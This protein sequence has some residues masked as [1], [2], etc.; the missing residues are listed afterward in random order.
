MVLTATSLIRHLCQITMPMVA[1]LR[2]LCASRCVSPKSVSTANI[3]YYIGTYWYRRSRTVKKKALITIGVIAVA[4]II[5]S[6]FGYLP[7]TFK[8]ESAIPQAVDL[9]IGDSVQQSA[10]VGNVAAIAPPSTKPAALSAPPIRLMTIPWNATMG[11]HYATGGVQTTEGSL[12]AKYGVKLRLEK[13]DDVEKMKQSQVLF[14]NALAKGQAH[15]T[16]GHHFVIIMGDG[17][18]Q[19]I[20]AL[21]DLLKDLGD[22]YRA[23]IV[24]AIGYSRG[25]DGC[26]GPQ[27]WKDNPESMKGGVIA[28][29]LRDGDWNLCLYKA[30]NDGIKNNPDETTY[31]PDAINWVS[32]SDFMKAV[33]LYVGNHCEDRKVVKLGKLTGESKHI[34]VQGVAT[35]TPGDVALAKNKGGLV[36]LISTK[37]NAYQ[38]PAVI[39]GIRAWDIRNSKLVEGLLQ[40]ALEGSEQVKHFDTA[41]SKAATIAA[42][43]YGDQTPAYWAKYY[44][45]T[46]ERDKTGAMVELGGSTT[47]NLADNLVLFGL[48]EGTGGLASSLYNATYTGFGNVVKQQYPKLFPSFTPVEQ[49]VNTQFIAALANRLKPKEE[50]ADVATFQTDAGPI[51]PEATV[52]KR[53]WSIQFATGS[54]TFSP[55]ATVTLQ[56]LYNQLL[57]G[58][59]LAVQIEGHTDNV[60][61]PDANLVLSQRRADAVRS[62]L[63][64]KSPKLFSEGRVNTLSYGQSKPKAD[65]SS[66]TGRA[67]NRRVT[68]VMGTQQ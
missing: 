9:S 53:D 20:T 16:V 26:Y 3:S 49:A 35:W 68:V 19:Y 66:E 64:V 31:D 6:Y 52:A 30:A 40:A 50:D 62:Y 2:V 54:A 61:N 32:T 59:A 17:G 46:R 29:Y 47:M 37:E 21:N 4:Y 36:R 44:R 41:L 28:G 45:G 56:E 13:Q 5:G 67:Q 33:E 48:A 12:M 7:G 60:G 14:A 24:G 11:L 65:N 63:Q 34:C 18:A 42:N 25:E 39:V 58:G 38:M 27:E 55:Q 15:P 22:D 10:P 51:A 8:Q 1:V 43:V 23:E 57:I